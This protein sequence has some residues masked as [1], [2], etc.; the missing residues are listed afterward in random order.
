MDS[1][2]NIITVIGFS[3]M[4]VGFIYIGRKL[5][6]L[7]DLKITVDKIKTN[8][9]VISD[10]L[11][12]KF[13][14]FNVSEIQAY[15][16]FSLTEVGEEF[17]QKLGFDKVFQDHKDDFFGFVGGESPKLKYDVETA[18][19]KSVFALS[20]NEYM[21]FLKIFL[22][23]NPERNLNNTAPTL[24]I[25]IKNQYLMAHPEITQ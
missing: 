1:V 23:N 3:S 15:S 10:F 8:L 25:Y 13:S 21:S 11:I 14:D 20:E 7:D 16:P 12:K 22:Y 5:Q 19:I 4:V 17:I 2:I 9:K 6:I 24:G 18:A